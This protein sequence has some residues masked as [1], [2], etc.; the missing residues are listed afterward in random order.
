MVIELKRV[1]LKRQPNFKQGIH[2][3]TPRCEWLRY[4][5][6]TE[7]FKLQCFLILESSDWDF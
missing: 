4:K 5:L 2:V 7:R 1:G 6:S 3:T